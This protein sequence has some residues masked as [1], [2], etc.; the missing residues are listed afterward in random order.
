MH[1]VKPLAYQGEHANGKKG[2][3]ALKW[4]NTS[5]TVQVH[6]RNDTKT[7]NASR[8]INETKV[9]HGV[10][11]AGFGNGLAHASNATAGPT[12]NATNQWNNKEVGHGVDGAGFGN[13]L[14]SANN[15]TTNTYNAS[16]LIN[17]TKVA[18]GVDGAGFGNGLSKQN[19]TNATS[20]VQA[21]TKSIDEWHDAQKARLEAAA[22]AAWVKKETENAEVKAKYEAFKA[23]LAKNMTLENPWKNGV[24][25]SGTDLPTDGTQDI[26]MSERKAL[27]YPEA[28]TGIKYVN[29]TAATVQTSSTSLSVASISKTIEGLFNLDPVPAVEAA[30]VIAQAVNAGD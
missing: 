21:K 18:H 1:E 16:R 28:P 15:A 27:P 9:A 29:T 23:D 2:P 24:M 5:A 19:A 10:D 14:V 12:Y 25:S 4:E 17:E 20:S 30:K 11:G 22:E 7:Y 3:L 8:L 13:G 6:N 26:P